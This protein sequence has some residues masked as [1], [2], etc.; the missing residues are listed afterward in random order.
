MTNKNQNI[1]DL[2][3]RFLAPEGWRSH[4]FKSHDMKINFGSVSPADTVPD[5]VVVCLPGLSEFCEKYYEV[6]RTC[7]DKNLAFWVLDWPGQGRSDRYFKGSQ[8]RHIDTFDTDVDRLH[9]FILGYIKHSAVHP[10]VGRIPLVM[11]GHSMGA[12]IGLRYL[13]KYPETFECAAFTSP[14]FGIQTVN[15]VPFSGFIL[16]LANLFMPRAYVVGGSDWREDMR[17]NSH[18]ENLFS[19]DPIRN[20]I[21]NA[22]CEVD[23]VLKVGSPTFGWLYRAAKSC[24]RLHRKEFLSNISTE[25][26]ITIAG[27]ETIVDNYDTSH[28][29]SN[30]SHCNMLEFHDSAHEI[31]MEVDHVRDKFFDAFYALIEKTIISKPETL[32]PF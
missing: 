13:E 16:W 5:A 7:L 29:V 24:K 28:V 3:E 6:A 27:K 1:P 19:H 30:L 4:H 12:N 18:N 26:L 15:K 2:E 23:P 20:E 17:K 11:L 14:M 21:T 22:W 10:D 31:L 8:K 9:E 32:K 25:C